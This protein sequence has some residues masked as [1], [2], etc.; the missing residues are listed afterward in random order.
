MPLTVQKL[1]QRIVELGENV[2]DAGVLLTPVYIT[3]AAGAMTPPPA[4][5]DSSWQE[6]RIGQMWGV[7]HGTSWLLTTLQVPDAMK[8][9][10]TVLR[11]HWDVRDEDPLL[12]G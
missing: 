2:E 9:Q 10:A 4:P 8:G 12:L 11:L 3:Q 7:E 6:L 5:G 1:Q